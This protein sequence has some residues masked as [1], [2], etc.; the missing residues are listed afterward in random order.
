MAREESFKTVGVL[1]HLAKKI[2]PLIFFLVSCFLHIEL[3]CTNLE[4]LLF[5]FNLLTSIYICKCVNYN[6][7]WYL[8]SFILTDSICYLF[9]AT[10]LDGTWSNNVQNKYMSI[11]VHYGQQVAGHALLWQR[12][13]SPKNFQS[14]NS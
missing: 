13:I 1:F 14:A 4:T 11:K 3:F 9:I 6:M 7:G 2:E 10:S 12:L 5:I 8:Q